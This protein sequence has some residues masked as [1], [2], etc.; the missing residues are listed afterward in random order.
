MKNQI[1][2]L[3]SDFE[4]LSVEPS[5]DLWDKLEEKLDNKIEAK[6]AFPYA[7][8]W[9]VAASVVLLFSLTFWLMND[10][11][12]ESKIIAKKENIA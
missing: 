2:K 1:D 6:K 8:W 12:E 5:S 4:N 11:K 9:I 3:K 7:K 10:E